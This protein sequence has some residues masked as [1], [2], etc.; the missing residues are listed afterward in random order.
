M[1]DEP[2]DKIEV[3]IDD[4]EETAEGSREDLTGEDNNNKS[5]DKDYNREESSSKELDESEEEED[6]K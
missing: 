1:E 5:S 2:K 4:K 6:N 3:N